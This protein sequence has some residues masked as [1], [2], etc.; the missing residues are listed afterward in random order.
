MFKKILVPLDG[1]E[2]AASILPQVAELAQ[3]FHSQL[4]LI[5]VCQSEPMEETLPTETKICEAY[6]SL[7]GKEFQDQGL[8]VGWVCVKGVPAREIIRYAD[9][10]NVDVIAMATHGRGE[11]AWVLGSTAMKVITHA[12]VPVM[13]F[14]IIHHEIPKL[15]EEWR[16]YL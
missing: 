3:K 14:R 7:L 15:K 2:L 4:T 6:L 12:T 1:S 13:L 8:Q 11:V 10:N 9:Q 16:R 5:H